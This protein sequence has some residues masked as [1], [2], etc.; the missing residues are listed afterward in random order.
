[1]H[2]YRL[3][4][5]SLPFFEKFEKF[6]VVSPLSLFHFLS[7]NIKNNSQDICTSR[8]KVVILQPK[9][10]AVRFSSMINI[11]EWSSW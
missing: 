1:M 9:F 4:E 11:A 5:N 6:V 8:K 3:M 2:N 10:A 7:G